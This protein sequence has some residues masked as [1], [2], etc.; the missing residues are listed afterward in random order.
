MSYFPEDGAVPAIFWAYNTIKQTGVNVGGTFVVQVA[1]NVD[2]SGGSVYP[3]HISF[4]YGELQTNGSSG[5]YDKFKAGFAYNLQAGGQGDQKSTNMVDYYDCDDGNYSK[6][7][8]LI[9]PFKYLANQGIPATT[10]SEINQ[11]RIFGVRLNA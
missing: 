6:S 1:N 9:N 7:D 2:L 3:D 5:Q 10:T 11:T 4:L 8:A